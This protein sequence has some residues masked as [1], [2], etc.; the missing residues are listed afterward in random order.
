MTSSSAKAVLKR[1]RVSPQKLNLV[2]AMIRG[3][4]VEYAVDVLSVCNKRIAVKV[5]QTLLSAVA[6]AEHNHELFGVSL[7]VK[8]AFVGSSVKMRRFHPRGR[9]RGSYI[10]KSFSHL[11]IVVAERS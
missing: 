9:G 5:L 7:F 10:R 3:M 4:R 6:N 1:I 2:A 11:S 8:E